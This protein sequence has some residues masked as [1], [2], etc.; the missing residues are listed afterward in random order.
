M[1]F[2]AKEQ[3]GPR[4]SEEGCGEHPRPGHTGGKAGVL[5]SLSVLTEQEGGEG[6]QSGLRRKSRGQLEALK[7]KPLL[8][9]SPLALFPEKVW[10]QAALALTHLWSRPLLTL[11]GCSAPHLLPPSSDLCLSFYLPL[12]N[13]QHILDLCLK[14]ATHLETP[15]AG[16]SFQT[17]GNT[18]ER[19]VWPP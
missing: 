14:T 12:T 9:L 5:S 15:P 10:L 19:K 16:H 4:E 8:L 17:G 18:A 6:G 2:L 11:P 13:P 3:P 7:C 1:S